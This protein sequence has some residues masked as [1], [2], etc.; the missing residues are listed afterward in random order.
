MVGLARVLGEWV[1]RLLV[2]VKSVIGSGLPFYF[3]RRMK[4]VLSLDLF[5]MRFCVLIII[6]EILSR[7]SMHFKAH[8]IEKHGVPVRLF[9]SICIYLFIAEI[10]TRVV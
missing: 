1:A 8:E 7:N 4:C 3:L 2:L 5:Y 6:I 9:I 10:V